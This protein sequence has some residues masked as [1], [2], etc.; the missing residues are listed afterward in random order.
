MESQNYKFSD[1]SLEY[2]RRESSINLALAAKLEE[3]ILTGAATDGIGNLLNNRIVGNSLDNVL[4]G[5]IGAD[6]LLGGAGNDTYKFSRGD[7]DDTILESD[8]TLGNQDV[9]NFESNV[10][11]DQLWFTRVGSDLEISVIGTTDRVTVSNW[12]E[13]SAS[14]IE[15]VAASDKILVDTQVQALVD[16]MAS[17]TPPPLGQTALSAA[18]VSALQPVLA[19]SWQ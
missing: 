19:S 15:Q 11:Y 4:E 7:E 18:Q 6:R 9:L 3:L 12:Y 8:T 13:G 5:D 16:A 1:A 14:R 10:A 17:M 2:V